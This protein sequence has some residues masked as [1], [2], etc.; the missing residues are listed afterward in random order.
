MR[1]AGLIL[2]PALLLMGCGRNKVGANANSGGVEGQLLL[3]AP[4][5]LPLPES[6]RLSA[7]QK[8][9]RTLIEKGWPDVEL[10]A[11]ATSQIALRIPVAPGPRADKAVSDLQSLQTVPPIQMIPLTNVCFR[12]PDGV[13]GPLFAP[14]E[15][16]GGLR[17]REMSTG[18]PIDVGEAV[19][20]TSGFNAFASFQITGADILPGSVTGPSPEHD[21]SRVV[22]FHTRTGHV[23]DWLVASR[24]LQALL[25]DGKIA[26]VLSPRGAEAQGAGR[27]TGSMAVQPGGDDSAVAVLNLPRAG[28]APKA[29]DISLGLSRGAVPPPPVNVRVLYAGPRPSGGTGPSQGRW[30]QRRGRWAQIDYTLP[31]RFDGKPVTPELCA[32]TLSALQERARAAGVESRFEAT[33]TKRITGW[34]RI[35]RGPRR[36]PGTTSYSRLIQRAEWAVL[37][38]RPRGEEDGVWTPA[39]EEGWV[40]WRR[41]GSAETKRTCRVENLARYLRADPDNVLITAEDAGPASAASDT[42]GGREGNLARVTVALKPAAA[43]R[44]KSLFAR[45]P[46]AIAA[47]FVDGVLISR[48]RLGD[49]PLAGDTV[50]VLESRLLP[51]YGGAAPSG[52]EISEVDAQAL[53]G[54]LNLPPIRLNFTDTTYRMVDRD[55]QSS[56]AGFAGPAGP[57]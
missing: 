49:R 28:R 20:S 14:I 30:G 51:L 57:R 40:V 19:G 35:F 47:L 16:I 22:T 4:Y 56:S 13:V 39:F 2:L 21:G 18:R 27:L 25:I 17:F 45:S 48:F 12:S 50:S 34:V 8:L 31:D 6:V 43:G 3:S 1:H 44:W 53:A 11:S 26:A 33:G 42:G 38:M 5:R 10:E 36:T 52:I 46:S 37:R 55:V 7:A 32:Q 29:E 23:Q 15:Y 54:L 41:P 24:T 9:Q